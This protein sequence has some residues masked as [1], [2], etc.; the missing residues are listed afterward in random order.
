[1][2]PDRLSALL[3]T[4]AIALLAVVAEVIHAPEAVR[5]VLGVPLA[6]VLPGFAAVCAVLPG[7]DL[8]RGETALATLGAS[9]GISICV[10][11]LLAA[12]PVGLSTGS[13]A[14]VL[15]LGTAAA[16]LY[17]WRRVRQL[18]AVQED[19]GQA[20]RGRSG[21]RPEPGFGRPVDGR[22]DNRRPTDRW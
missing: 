10:A 8:S 22:P 3:G 2:K 6:L 20:G 4:C 7:R 19:G 18:P 9:M 11:T 5:V 14:V 1:M 15:G 21:A 16:S 17:A 12:T 13:A